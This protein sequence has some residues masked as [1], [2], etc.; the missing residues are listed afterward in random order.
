VGKNILEYFS[1]ASGGGN[2]E[3]YQRNPDDYLYRLDPYAQKTINTG[4]DY[5]KGLARDAAAA[6]Q[7]RLAG[8]GNPAQLSAARSRRNAQYAASGL[9]NVGFDPGQAPMQAAQV[10]LGQ[11][12]RGGG[13]AK[14]LAR[15]ITGRPEGQMTPPGGGDRGPSFQASQDP[16]KAPAAMAPKFKPPVIEK[17]KK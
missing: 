5:T 17:D 14:G 11:D 16:S 1:G 8:E 15:A 9:P 3:T 12:A 4:M 6:P 13:L 10:R 2:I 7:I